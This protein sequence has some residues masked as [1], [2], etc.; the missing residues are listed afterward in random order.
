MG[1]IK[2]LCDRSQLYKSCFEVIAANYRDVLV[3]RNSEP[4]QRQALRMALDEMSKG[5][6]DSEEGEKR[7]G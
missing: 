5:L 6:K 7:Y 2:D 1:Y 3:V 4:A